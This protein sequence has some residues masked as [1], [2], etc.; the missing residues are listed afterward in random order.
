MQIVK[1][2]RFP[3]IAQLGDRIVYMK[4]GHVNY[5][6]RVEALKLYDV[7]NKMRPP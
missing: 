6:E 2:K 7:K 3:Y 5:L 4:Q 1:S